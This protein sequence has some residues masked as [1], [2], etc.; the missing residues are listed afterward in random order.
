MNND[1]VA[2]KAGSLKAAACEGGMNGCEVPSVVMKKRKAKVGG[3]DYAVEKQGDG[4]RMAAW[5]AIRGTQWPC[6]STS[7]SL[8]EAVPP[9]P[10]AGSIRSRPRAALTAGRGLG[11]GL[12]A[13]VTPIIAH[14]RCALEGDCSP[15]HH[16]HHTL[17]AT[18][19]QQTPVLLS[20]LTRRQHISAISYT[21]LRPH[22]H[23][24]LPPSADLDAIVETPFPPS[25]L[26]P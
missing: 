5:L 10:P 19:T 23:S 6:T 9:D 21:C 26:P 13:Q 2:D 20:I 15:S 7:T 18:E 3:S 22:Q 4:A 11:G 17:S 24:P 25:V 1:C 8:P 12:P 14:C 16:P